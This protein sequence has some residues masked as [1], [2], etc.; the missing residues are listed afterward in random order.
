MSVSDINNPANEVPYDPKEISDKFDPVKE[1]TPKAS[2][3]ETTSPESSSPKA[4]VPESS[5]DSLTLDA[6]KED[7]NLSE[8]IRKNKIDALN[9]FLAIIRTFIVDTVK[10]DP[11]VLSFTIWQTQFQPSLI[12]KIATSTKSSLNITCIPRGITHEVGK[13][14]SD[15]LF[16]EG[17]KVSFITNS[18]QWGISIAITSMYA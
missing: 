1:L 15:A 16:K 17:I 5:S 11:Y 12:E 2:S 14:I 9:E 18:R 3:P 4:S 6:L 10:V 8:I 7:S 13:Y